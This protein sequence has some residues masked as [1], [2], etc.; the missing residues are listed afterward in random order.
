MANEI[1]TH[2][3]SEKHLQGYLNVNEVFGEKTEVEMHSVVR[4]R[5]ERNF[6]LILITAN[7]FKDVLFFDL[8][9]EH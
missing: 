1:K 2:V 3:A 7:I 5:L 8:I 9:K 6:Q 4:N